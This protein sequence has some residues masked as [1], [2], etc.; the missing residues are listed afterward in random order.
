MGTSC[1][2]VQL[3]NLVL[4]PYDRREIITSILTFLQRESIFHDMSWPIDLR[5]PVKGTYPISEAEAEEIS[6]RA[7]E[8]VA[9]LNV[10]LSDDPR[11]RQFNQVLLT[12][13]EAQTFHI[14]VIARQFT[15]DAEAWFHER[16]VVVPVEELFAARHGLTADDLENAAWERRQGIRGI[17]FRDEKLRKAGLRDAFFGLLDMVRVGEEGYESSYD[18]FI[19]GMTPETLSKLVQDRLDAEVPIVSSNKIR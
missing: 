9:K 5:Q 2:V 8:E 10:K 18:S 17:L 12:I 19:A 3:Y 13:K 15:N 16:K 1:Q 11:E 6:L 7:H 14:A 4:N